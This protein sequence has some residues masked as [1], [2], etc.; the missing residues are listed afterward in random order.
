MGP[1]TKLLLRIMAN[2]MFKLDILRD[3]TNTKVAHG[4]DLFMMW[5]ASVLAGLVQR[6]T[7][8]DFEGKLLNLNPRI[9]Y[10]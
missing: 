9:V 8:D 5:E 7:A 4:D 1:V 3:K 6:W 2:K 10:P